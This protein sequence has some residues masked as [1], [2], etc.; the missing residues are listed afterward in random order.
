MNVAHE[1][2]RS[3]WMDVTVAA[4]VVLNT[5][6]E[7]I[8]KAPHGFRKSRAAGDVIDRRRSINHQLRARDK[9]RFI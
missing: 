9:F 6:A 5:R 3:L 8:S 2:T 7:R 1:R 4:A